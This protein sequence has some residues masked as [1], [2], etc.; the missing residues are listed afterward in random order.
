MGFTYASSVPIEG[1]PEQNKRGRAR[2][3]TFDHLAAALGIKAGTAQNYGFP[4]DVFELVHRVTGAW[5][6]RSR[7]LGRLELSEWLAENGVAGRDE[8][9]KR[10]PRLHLW[11]CGA[12]R[13]R[14][15]TLGAPGVCW[16]HGV[17]PQWRFT[18]TGL[19]ALRLGSEF[20][21]L[22]RVITGAAPGT[23]VVPRDNN[24]WNN[25]PDNLLVVESLP[26]HTQHPRR[27]TEKNVST[28]C[29]SQTPPQIGWDP[30]EN[31]V[32]CHACGKR[33][34]PID[35]ASLTVIDRTE[36]ICGL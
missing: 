34:S 23:L 33:F 30:K 10:W 22:H 28:L 36:E 15:I 8:W 35:G 2:H 21:P 7:Q 14:K 25:R 26:T 32:R 1:E 5:R 19:F 29:C 4:G 17:V 13:C 24:P 9:E 6:R 20:V 3:I 31:A 16:D 12:P 27:E 18:E 11:R